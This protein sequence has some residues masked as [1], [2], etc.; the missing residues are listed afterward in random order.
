VAR[1]TDVSGPGTV[2]S[3]GRLRKSLLLAVAL[4]LAGFMVSFPGPTLADA[5]PADSIAAQ[6]DPHDV[7]PERPTVATHAYCVAPG[8]A[9]VETG[10]EFDRDAPARYAVSM[11]TTMKLGVAHRFQLN[12][13]QPLIRP[14][15]E[16]AGVGDVSVGLK[17]QVLAGA[18]LLRDVALMPTL[19]LASGSVARGEGTGTTDASLLAISSRTLGAVEVDA[20]LGVTRRGGDGTVAPRTATLW[21]LA[22]GAPLTHVLGLALEVYGYPG[23]AGPAGQPPVVA[24]LAGPTVLVRGWLELDAGMIVPITGPQPTAFYAGGVANLGRCW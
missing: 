16:R 1:P 2:A 4:G 22:A 6:R 21:T 15:D 8:W 5:S 12:L 19:K 18:P 9:E 3:S 17:W 13:T 11:P 20:N 10:V 7:Q 23:T 24:A 14:L